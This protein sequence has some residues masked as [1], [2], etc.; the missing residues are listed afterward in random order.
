MEAFVAEM[1]A[2]DPDGLAEQARQMQGSVAV[3]TQSN[4]QA[5]TVARIL[6]GMACRQICWL[7]RRIGRSTRGSPMRSRTHRHL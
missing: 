2:F 5:L 7:A 3:L 4:A 6:H 1:P